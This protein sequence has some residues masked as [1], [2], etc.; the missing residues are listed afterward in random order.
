MKPTHNSDE[1]CPLTP[2]LVKKTSTQE[3]LRE[4]KGLPPLILL[5]YPSGDPRSHITDS[6]SIKMR[7]S[8]S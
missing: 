8:Y 1:Y 3:N 4:Q 5:L 6:I 2:N 7:L